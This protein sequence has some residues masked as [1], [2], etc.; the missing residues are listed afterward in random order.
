MVEGSAVSMLNYTGC[1]VYA[2]CMLAGCWMPVARCWMLSSGFSVLDASMPIRRTCIKLI[3]SDCIRR[4][5]SRI[6]VQ[7]RFGKWY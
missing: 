5:G 1:L 3:V 4:L 7:I 6:V 2:W